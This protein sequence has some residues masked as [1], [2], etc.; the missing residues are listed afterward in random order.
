MG[1]EKKGEG[2]GL[3]GMEKGWGEGCRDKYVRLHFK[4]KDEMREVV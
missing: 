1:I 4:T 3:M 2:G